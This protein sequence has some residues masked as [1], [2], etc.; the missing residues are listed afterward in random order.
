MKCIQMNDDKQ[1]KSVESLTSQ[2]MKV[3]TSPG[4]LKPCN[5]V[6]LKNSRTVITKSFAILKSLE[7]LAVCMMEKRYSLYE[8]QILTE[9]S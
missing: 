3:H 6:L 7:S 2:T 5:D 9:I 8:R 1:T 4:I